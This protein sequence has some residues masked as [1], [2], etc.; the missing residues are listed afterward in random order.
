MKEG[1]K[2]G[3][4]V[5]PPKDKMHRPFSAGHVIRIDEMTVPHPEAD[6]FPLMFDGQLFRP[7]QTFVSL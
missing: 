5:L 6:V 2:R 7:L 3:H 1:R 4:G